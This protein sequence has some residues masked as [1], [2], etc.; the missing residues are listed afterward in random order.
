MFVTGGQDGSLH[1][2]SAE[3]KKPISTVKAAH[4]GPLVSIASLVGTDLIATGS[5]DGFIRFWR[6][7]QPGAARQAQAD[8][9][10]D[11]DAS[12]DDAGDDAGAEAGSDAA[13][14][15]YDASEGGSGAASAS[16]SVS[17]PLRESGLFREV[18]R[19]SVDGFVNGL[20]FAN[21]GTRLVAAVGSEHRMGR[22]WRM[23]NVKAGIVVVDLPA[24]VATA[25]APSV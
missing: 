6:V 18:A 16:V 20:A 13:A 8:A 10:D 5:S 7:V 3:R 15:G 14:A 17:P 24:A 25:L 21:E 9:D 12:D 11:D 2:W 22:W 19:V 23:K 1:L 4:E